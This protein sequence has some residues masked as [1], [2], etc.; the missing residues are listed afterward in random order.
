M[1]AAVDQ[2]N[3]QM[4]EIGFTVEQKEVVQEDRTAAILKNRYQKEGK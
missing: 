2:K 1:S 3:A 4:D